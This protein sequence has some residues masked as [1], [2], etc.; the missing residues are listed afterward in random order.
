MDRQYNRYG[1][2]WDAYEFSTTLVEPVHQITIQLKD[3]R[4]HERDDAIRRG[5]IPDPK[6]PVRLEDAIS[7]IGTCRD[8]CPEFERHERE[9][10]QNVEKFE[11]IPGTEHI[12]HSRAVKAFA[13]PAAGADQPLPSDV[14]PPDVLLSTLAY[15]MEEI[16]IKGDLADSHA[17]VRDRTRSIRQDFTLQNHRGPEAIEAH[18]IIARYHILCIHQLCEDKNFSEQQ[19][20]EQLRKVLT[21]LQ[22]F[23]DDMRTEGTPCPNEAEFRAYHMLSHLQDP[24]MMR[25]AQILPHHIFLDPYIQTAAEVNA[26]TRR[27]NDVR[28]RAVVQSEASPNFFSRFFK[29]VAG[30]RVTYLMACLLEPNFGEIRKGG[31]KA[32]NKSYLDQHEGVLVSDLVNI[33]G[34]DDE[35]E[36]ITNCYEYEL[37]LAN[38]SQP[39][40][41]FGRKDQVSRRR[42]F[43]EGAVSIKQHRNERI[44]EAKRQNY[45]TLQ[46]I[47]GETPR[48]QQRNAIMGS[49]SLP[50]SANIPRGLTSAG[51]VSRLGISTAG[52]AATA[53]A[54]SAASSRTAL[55]RTTPSVAATPSRAVNF[56]A[57]GSVGVSQAPGNSAF[58]VSSEKA[59]SSAPSVFQQPLVT[60]TA[61]VSKPSAIS[62]SYPA[63]PTTAVA[64]LSANKAPS[65]NTLHTHSTLNPAAPS[66]TLST[67]SVPSF[68]ALKPIISLPPTASP[69]ISSSVPGQQPP[70]F[71]FGTSSSA[72][73]VPF[74]FTGSTSLP[75][76]TGTITTSSSPQP[77]S[78]ASFL[79]SIPF[80]A[81]G[82]LS[83]GSSVFSSQPAPPSF[84]APPAP[85]KSDANNIVSRRGKV[86]PRAMVEAVMNEF[87]QKE[88]DRLIRVTAAQISQEVIMERSLRRAK[89]REEAVRQESML[90]LSTLMHQ[91]TNDLTEEILAELYRETSLQRR[92]I[93][94]WKDYTAK[95]LQRAEELRRRQ[96][97]FLANV[98]SMGSSAGLVDASPMAVRIRD[99]NAQQQRIHG[100]HVSAR[101]NGEIVGKGKEGIKAMVEAVSNKRKRLLS[102]GQEGSLDLALVAGLRKVVAPKRE[103]WAP[104]PVFRIVESSYHGTSAGHSQ[105]QQLA[106]PTR[107]PALMKR[108]WRLFVNTPNFK[109]MTSK[110]LLTKLGIDMGRHT[111]AQQRSGTMVAVHRGPSTD[112]DNTMDVVVHGSEDQSVKDL[113]G[114]SKYSIMET[115]AF[116]FEFSKLPFVDRDATDTAIRGYWEGEHDRL[117]RFLS[118][119]PKVKQPVV[120]IIWTEAPEIWER[121]SPH[122]VEY[123]QL[124]A[125]VVAPQGPLLSYRFLRLDM[126]SMKLDPYIVGSLEWLASE[127][128]DFFEDPAV[129]LEALLDK[130]RPIY[131]WALTRMSLAEGPM[132]SQFDEDDEEEA[133]MWRLRVRK[134]KQ[135]QESGGKR[136]GLL[137]GGQ[138]QRDQMELQ[139]PR[140]MFV[141]TAE[142]G[143]NLAVKLFN[144]ELESIA[145]TIETKGQGETREGAV[146]EGRVKDAMARFIRQAELPEMKR[147]AVQDRLNFGMDSRSALSDFIDVYVAS[148][149]GLAKE[150]QNLESK[151]TLRQNVWSILTLS[152]EDRVPLED[153]FAAISSQVLQW[154]KA[155]IL[156]TERFSVRIR[157]WEQQ[158]SDL[159]RLQGQ[160]RTQQRQYDQGREEEKDE[161]GKQGEEDSNRDRGE[162][163]DVEEL[164]FAPILIHDEVDVEGNV[165]DFES[166]V[167]SEVR[168]WEKSV[169]SRASDREERA[170]AVERT[171][172]EQG[173]AAA[174]ASRKRSAPERPRD[175]MKKSRV[176]LV[177]NTSK[178]GDDSYD[179]YLRHTLSPTNDAPTPVSTLPIGSA[180]G[181]KRPTGLETAPATLGSLRMTLPQSSLP[182][183]MNSSTAKASLL[184]TAIVPAAK[185]TTTT[186]TATDR[187]AR[188]RSLIK[189]VKET[190]HLS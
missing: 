163:G 134:R 153:V 158:R 136:D 109:D 122:M 47:Y 165:F 88:T 50:S 139:Q 105:N 57:S 77:P 142:S 93:S 45:A 184:T 46:I 115:A 89:E 187:M 160:Y 168:A 145:Q 173:G 118:C 7:F 178:S 1:Y 103:M 97:H 111:K 161:E 79:P 189:E 154:V 78:G 152:K 90:V 151:A 120:F 70:S 188:L 155:G 60:G 143:F 12:D 39:A 28:R 13:R 34:F 5:D 132:Y 82:A 62:M 113:L 186:T 149:G 2:F 117:V 84:S 190:K 180:T 185:T 167:Q 86:F 133:H 126:S 71:A 42:I 35:E 37:E 147:G 135:I 128:K 23:Y 182:S 174:G 59:G 124:D 53:A 127:T 96:E 176:E 114:M 123:L 156:D 99:Y 179:L 107:G 61:P 54:T 164:A 27:N 24:D 15:L 48:P 36:C 162:T 74:S 101:R 3:K 10:Q 148:L 73:S 66:F 106:A 159:M 172:L 169:K 65:T 181:T 95:C 30:P 108:R 4:V 129:L 58:S 102:I 137:L 11:K 171:Q 91:I 138:Q 121:V 32:L 22:E 18:E 8:M 119:F 146:Q 130:Y 157:K 33:L 69:S 80:T 150:Q 81:T 63:V 40:V 98:R 19:E 21:S 166:T 76:S 38:Q 131:E 29:M 72:S 141:E 17:F 44:V 75:L 140:N 177:S 83:S 170:L 87:V 112:D 104:L 51:A 55:S 68:T 144:M 52:A 85:A 31:L 64:A 9:Y 25:Q 41:I 67:P 175:A 43:K 20:M 26:L 183:A 100:T 16:V 92:V 110:W 14:R 56:G 94:Q 6:K 116:I 125:M 49:I